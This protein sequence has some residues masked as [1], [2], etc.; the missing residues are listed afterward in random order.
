MSCDICGK[1]CGYTEV[2]VP[3]LEGYQTDEI[4]Q[5][6]SK[7]ESNVNRHL[8]KLKNL[9]DGWVRLMLKMWMMNT[10]KL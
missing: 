10:R 3:L 9:S 4:K 5:I 2:L 8:F 7:C 6:C 1:V